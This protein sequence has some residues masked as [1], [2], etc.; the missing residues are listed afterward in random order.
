ML[1]EDE[2]IDI[3]KHASLSHTIVR[4]FYNSGHGWKKRFS[5]LLKNAL[6]F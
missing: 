3:D 1:D 2:V 4:Q 6:E 5:I